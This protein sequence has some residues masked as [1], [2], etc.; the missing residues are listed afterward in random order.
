MKW[1]WRSLAASMGLA[2]TAISI[3]AQVQVSSQPL[4]PVVASSSAAAISWTT[5]STVPVLATPVPSTSAAAE[6]QYATGAKQQSDVVKVLPS[7]NW[8]VFGG[9]TFIRFHASPIIV[10]SRNG[11]SYSVQYFYKKGWFGGDGEFVAAFGSVSGFSSHFLTGMG[12][13]RVRWLASGGV[14]LWGHGLAGTSHFSP[15]TPYGNQDAFGYEVGGGVDITA[16]HRHFAYRVQGDMVG[17]RF[18]SA[19]QYSPRISTGVVLK[20]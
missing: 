15:R 12:G 13:A 10:A 6:P 9:Y 1:F 7:Y 17:T 4:I 11:F 8:Q 18:Y 16:H 19:N 2:L 5:P 14:E 20:F 3:N